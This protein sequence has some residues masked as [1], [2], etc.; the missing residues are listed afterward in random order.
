MLGDTLSRPPPEPRHTHSSQS[1]EAWASAKVDLSPRPRY[2]A[3]SYTVAYPWRG[4]GRIRGA[5]CYY[6]NGS[7]RYGGPLIAFLRELFKALGEKPPAASTLFWDVRYLN[8][9]RERPH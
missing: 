7:K 1:T 8:T 5:D 9:E 6:R 4:D 3:R 2:A